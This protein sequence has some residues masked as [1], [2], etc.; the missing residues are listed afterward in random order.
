MTGKAKRPKVHKTLRLLRRL[1]TYF[2][3]NEP[4]EDNGLTDWEKKFL[5]DLMTRLET[6]GTAFPEPP[7][8]QDYPDYDIISPLQVQKLK[9]I[10]KKYKAQTKTDKAGPDTSRFDYEASIAGSDLQKTTIEHKPPIF[11]LIKGGMSE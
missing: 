8:A 9:E 2:D 11:K 5:A 7:N 10:E 3:E 4:Q 1:A 6:H